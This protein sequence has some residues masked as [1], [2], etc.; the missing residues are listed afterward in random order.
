MHPDRESDAALVA[1]FARLRDQRAFA[2]LMRRHG[3]MVLGVCLRKLGQ[4][5]DAEDALQAVFL[6]LSAKARTLRRVRSL[7]GWLHNVAVRI[8]LNLLKMNRRREQ[9]LRSFQERQSDKKEA[10]LCQFSEV[11]DEELAQLPARFREVIVKCDLQGYTRS[12]AA[13]RLSLPA[14]T[15]DSRLNRARTLLR[16][17]LLRRG[18]TI[19]VGGVAGAMAR[20]AEA[21]QEM[22][23]ALVDQTVRM[24]ELFMAGKSV[25]ASTA[26]TK[27]TSL[28]QGVVHTMFLSKLSTTVCIL[29]LAA[30]LV[31]GAS[32]VSKMVGLMSNVRAGEYFL[33]TFDDDNLYDASPVTW[34]K[35][36]P[37]YDQGTIGAVNGNLVLTPPETMPPFDFVEMDA[38]VDGL[39]FGDVSLRTRVR[40]QRAGDS[41][42]GLAA[43]ITFPPDNSLVGSNMAA[44]LVNNGT[45]N[46]WTSLNEQGQNL[47]TV[48]TTLDPSAYDVNLQFDV[49]GRRAT[50]TAWRDGTP[51]PSA[52]Q[53][54]VDPIPDY[55]ADEG[56]VGLFN[57]QL[58]SPNPKIPIEYQYFQAVPEPSTVALASLGIVALGA[59]GVRTRLSG[60][61]SAR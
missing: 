54:I 37:P 17:R 12:E 33:D 28:A 25:G 41:R 6:T 26:A 19:G 52:P 59:F 35:M 20:V 44:F 18:V 24:A 21:A 8:S 4:R 53:L 23:G 27:I 49:V 48:R 10:R 2:E 31:L 16:D 14:G 30:A 46:I 9:G 11:V 50:F 22:P 58:L 57:A 56:F 34:R 61:R 60:D 15:V 55:V 7:S 32:P 3:P 42:A 39:H 13:R 29:A 51:M 38:A 1:R 43:R 45:L 40:A 5:Q 36:G 47:A